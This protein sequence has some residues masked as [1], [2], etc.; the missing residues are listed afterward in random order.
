ML[1]TPKTSK[2]TVSAFQRKLYRKAKQQ[3]ECRFY[4]LY[5]KKSIVPR[6]CKQRMGLSNKTEEAPD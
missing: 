2:E 1:E 4:S 3:S 6:Y 5:D